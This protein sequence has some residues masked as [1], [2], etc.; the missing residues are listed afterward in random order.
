MKKLKQFWKRLWHDVPKTARVLF[1]LGV[2]G[3]LLHMLALLFPRVADLLLVSVSSLLRAALAYL[4]ALIPFSLAEV[5]LLGLPLWVVLLVLLSRRALRRHGSLKRVCALLL[6]FLPLL[7]TLFVFTL[8]VGYATSPPE[9]RLGLREASVSAESLRD[10][11][12]WLLDGAEAE[13]ASIRFDE[14]GSSVMPF[15]YWEMD[16]QLIRAYREAKAEIPYLW[17]V[18]VGTKRILFSRPMAYTGITGVYSFFTGEANICTAYPDYSVLYTAAH[19]MAHARG[20]AR[21]DEA[22]FVAFLALKNSDE[23]YL[24]Y[25]AYTNL[26]QYVLGALYAADRGMHKEVYLL[27]PDAI[28]QEYLAYNAFLDEVGDHPVRDVAEGINNAYLEGMGT[29][30]TLSYSLV[31]RLAVAYYASISP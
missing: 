1:L 18:R 30:G 23:P 21:E 26:L 4:T 11:A 22:N 12:L 24:R 8:G 9:K 13:L 17:D 16:R 19:E 28:R 6:S 5:L 7:Y 20:A 25:A 3:F 14:K 31:T 27:L 10:T 15:S 2:A 29:E